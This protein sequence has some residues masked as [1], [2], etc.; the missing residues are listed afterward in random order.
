M[1]IS[2]WMD[3]FN[4]R[5]SGI[6]G[7]DCGWL[8]AICWFFVSRY[9]RADLYA[10]PAIAFFREPSFRFRVYLGAAARRRRAH[11][12][13]FLQLSRSAA[14]RSGPNRPY[15]YQSRFGPPDYRLHSHSLAWAP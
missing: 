15:D 8:D 7:F 13:N 1:G 11:L 5:P 3:A 2:F 12:V 6:P 10:P 9:R 4:R 14:G